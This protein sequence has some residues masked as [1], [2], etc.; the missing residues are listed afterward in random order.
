MI[1]SSLV[2]K[3]MKRI[4]NLYSD[5]CTIENLKKDMFPFKTTIIKDGEKFSFS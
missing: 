4:G 2:A 3:A 1:N 5:I